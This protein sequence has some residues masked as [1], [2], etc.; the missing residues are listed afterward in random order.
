MSFKGLRQV[1]SDLQR[2]NGIENPFAVED[3]VVASNR[4]QL[5]IRENRGSE[6]L[7]PEVELR[8]CLHSELLEKTE[9]LDLP[10]DFDLNQLNDL[11]V[12]IE[13]LSHFNTY[14]LRAL[15]QRDITALELEVQGEVDKFGI[16][17]DWLYRRNENHLKTV[18]FDQLFGDYRLG[19]WVTEKE[20]ERYRDAHQIAKN[21]CR[22]LLK[23]DL[24]QNELRSRFRE[25]FAKS[26]DSKLSSKH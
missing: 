25:F 23:D 4:N 1:H 13:E 7:E 20:I 2:L 5:L 16:M 14:C 19:D 10:R 9:G 22:S 11:S 21:F 24:S 18:V 12:V 17:V 8:I 15:E 3:F 6:S 26:A